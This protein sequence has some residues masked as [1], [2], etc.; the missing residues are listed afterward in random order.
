MHRLCQDLIF[1]EKDR[2]RRFALLMNTSMRLEQRTH[3]ALGPR[4]F[5]L[6]LPFA[7]KSALRD[8]SLYRRDQPHHP[9]PAL[10]ALYDI[11]HATTLRQALDLCQLVPP[12]QLELLDELF[13]HGNADTFFPHVAESRAT[14]ARSRVTSAQS[15]VTSSR[16]T[17]TRRPSKMAQSTARFDAEPVIDSWNTQ[18]IDSKATL[19]QA[20]DFTLANQKAVHQKSEAVAAARV[21]APTFTHPTTDTVHPYSTQTLNTREHARDLMQATLRSMADTAGGKLYTY[22]DTFQSLA[23]PLVDERQQLKH[24]QTL[25]RT[26]WKTQSGLQATKHV[27]PP[28]FQPSIT[29]TI[30]DVKPSAKHED[31]R[32]PLPWDKRHL[33]F[34]LP[35]Y[36]WHQSVTCHALT[37]TPYRR[38]PEPTKEVS[39]YLHTDISQEART[40]AK[41]EHELWQRSVVVSDT[42]FR[43]A[44]SPEHPSLVDKSRPLLQDAPTKA[45]IRGKF[46][47]RDQPLTS[48]L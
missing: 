28:Q 7:I 8:C 19:G 37:T 38:A 44:R 6:H 34:C 3:A 45:G 33:D 2:H 5:Q 42:R 48:T 22:S 27:P 18:F 46:A 16:S 26:Q 20:R 15:R 17:S 36:D 12:S 39:M 32:G 1:A 21:K 14:S 29:H 31:T 24:E 40:T 41:L 11:G 30:D 23:F 4:L 10:Q 35:R 13:C 9:L 47:L 43:V 25:S